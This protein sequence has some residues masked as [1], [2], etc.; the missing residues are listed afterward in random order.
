MQYSVE[1]QLDATKYSLA[2]N[3]AQI[4]IIINFF[5]Q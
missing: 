5:K 4:H 3:K 1:K 2:E